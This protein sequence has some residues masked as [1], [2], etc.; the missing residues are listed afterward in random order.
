VNSGRTRISFFLLHNVKLLS[1]ERICD[2]VILAGLVKNFSAGLVN[3]SFSP[4]DF[5]IRIG[6]RHC[7]SQWLVVSKDIYILDCL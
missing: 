5:R 2:E 3:A 6:F 7:E 4:F 1:K